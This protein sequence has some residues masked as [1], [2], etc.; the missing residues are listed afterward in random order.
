[1]L[2]NWAS[3]LTL[4]LLGPATLVGAFPSADHLHKLMGHPGH[5]HP[6]NASGCPY[7]AHLKDSNHGGEIDKR[8]LFSLMNEP[9]DS[10]RFSLPEEG[11]IP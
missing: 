11:P 1:M 8:F 9:I 7:A 2:G 10:R 6:R 4:A 3:A 5:G